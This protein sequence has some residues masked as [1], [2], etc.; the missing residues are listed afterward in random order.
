MNLRRST[1]LCRHC[2]AAVAAALAA[3]IVLAVSPPASGQDLG[4]LFF[5]PEQRQM[6]DRQRQFRSTEIPQE[7]QIPEDPTLT[8][9]GVVTRSSGRRTVWING[10]A[11]HETETAGGTTVSPLDRNPGSV[12]VHSDKS[13]ATRAKVGATINRNTGESA[14][15]IGDGH[16]RSTTKLAP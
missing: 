5:T 3:P 2:T 4:R 9:N 6:L 13:P 11:Q 7:V 8:I 1:R 15:V 16:I 12:I 10:V 14:D